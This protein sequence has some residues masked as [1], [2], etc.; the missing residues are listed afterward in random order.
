M[1]YNNVV[2]QGS[3]LQ[4]YVSVRSFY[5]IYSFKNMINMI[6]TTLYQLAD[7]GW[8]YIYSMAQYKNISYYENV[9]ICTQW[10]CKK[11]INTKK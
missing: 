2:P 7:T 5:S 11:I 10:F 6:N 3:V 9:A 4:L 8:L 1:V